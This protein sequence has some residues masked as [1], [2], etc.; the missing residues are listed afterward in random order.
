MSEG[1]ES[2]G[3]NGDDGRIV[4]RGAGAVGGTNLARIFRAR[5]R[6]VYICASVD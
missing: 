2:V 6:S 1:A 3:G 4:A 5:P